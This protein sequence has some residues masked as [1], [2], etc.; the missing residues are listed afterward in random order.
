[1]PYL[2]L[3]TNVPRDR[4]CGLPQLLQ[5]LSQLVAQHLA[6]DPKY[7]SVAVIPGVAMAWNGDA[8]KPCGNAVLTSV[9][10]IG[11]EE[12]KKFAAEFY[13]VLDKHLAITGERSVILY[14]TLSFNNT[15]LLFLKDATSCSTMPRGP[16]SDLT[17]PRF[18]SDKI[19][20][21]SMNLHT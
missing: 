8:D 16:T 21:Q 17:A 18:T 1:M 4:I 9:G 7:V 11:V 20:H 14:Y 19:V 6:K 3:E 2:R 10:G 5:S 13:P 12:N 15:R